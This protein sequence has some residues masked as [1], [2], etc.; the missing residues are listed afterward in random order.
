MA[1]RKVADL[2]ACGALV[3]VV[4]PDVDAD[5]EALAR[6][7]RALTVERRPYAAGEAGRYRLVVTATGI[8]EVDRQA[9]DDAEAAGIWVNSADDADHCT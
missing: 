2:V 3:T 7:Q 8:P 1:A 4:A 9:A 5:I 6:S